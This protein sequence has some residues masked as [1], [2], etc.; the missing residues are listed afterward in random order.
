VGCLSWW[1]AR[2]LFR[3]SQLQEATIKPA[4]SSPSRRQR[5]QQDRH[6]NDTS[7]DEALAR[8]LQEQEHRH[9]DHRRVHSDDDALQ[10]YARTLQERAFRNLVLQGEKPAT[11]Q[12]QQHHQSDLELA[13]RMQEWEDRGVSDGGRY[14]TTSPHNSA[15]NGYGNYS[16]NNDSAVGGCGPPYARPQPQPTGYSPLRAVA[17]SAP[18]TPSASRQRDGNIASMSSNEGVVAGMPVFDPDAASADLSSRLDVSLPIQRDRRKAAFRN[19]FPFGSTSRSSTNDSD[20]KPLPTSSRSLPASPMRSAATMLSAVPPPPGGSISAPPPPAGAQ[21][22]N[23]GPLPHSVSVK[24]G[25]TTSGKRLQ[26]STSNVCCVCRKSGGSPF[27]AAL[28]RKYHVSC[29]RCDSCCQQIETSVSFAFTVDREGR[30]RPQHR[31]CYARALSAT[32]AVCRHTIPA[33]Q[34]GTVCFVKH[35]F[36]E[37]EQMCP[38][39]ADSPGRRCTGCHRFEPENEPFAD[40]HDA[41]RCVCYACCRTVVVDNA[42]VMPLWS[43]VLDFFE[44]TLM[45]PVWK[46]MRDI[47]ILVVQSD[48]LNDHLDQN[49]AHRGASQI[50]ARGLCLTDHENLDRRLKL[51]SV[52]FERSSS[53][54]KASDVEE[55]G[56][57]FFDVPDDNGDHCN[58]DANVFA[59]LCLSGLPRDLTTSILAHEATHA[60]IKLHP[61]Y[62]C[63]N[64]LPAQVEEGCAQLIS[65]LLLTDGLDATKTSNADES[66][67]P[68]DDQLRRYF[69]FS[70]E[71]DDDE[72]YGEGYRKA[73]AAYRNIGIDA[74]LAHVVRYRA[75]PST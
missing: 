7:D 41:G 9:G 33:M 29:F 25:T 37:T 21:Q 2:C 48:A 58:P 32:C 49:P 59:I 31:D 4:M 63:S 36:F 64:P 50:M 12:Q 1:L 26:P 34:D 23:P 70:I 69:K 51:A 28:D 40:L 75:F 66:S 8:M 5:R 38:W 52:K 60:W 11:E 68:S 27:I 56:F 18:S 39:H 22:Q 62:D 10:Q 30:K 42:D 6:N 17:H 35:P 74:L 73:A 54:F 57:T 71:R 44:N 55:Q 16:S 13:R 20:R 65:M 15:N 43:R 61:H 47:P 46:P 67:G 24:S 3:S 19:L 72:I 45:L 14:H 53:Q